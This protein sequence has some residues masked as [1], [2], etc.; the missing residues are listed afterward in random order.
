MKKTFVLVALLFAALTGR[1]CDQCGCGL[2]LGVQP[3]DHANNFGLQWH[4]RYL[5]GDLMNPE[6]SSVE[7]M[8]KHG[9]AAAA[10]SG[11]VA[12]SSTYTEVYSV[13]EARA[14]F[15][16]GQRF[17]LTGSVPLLNNFQ[18]VDNIRHADV[19]AVG[20]PILLARYA[21][22][23]SV[24]GPDTTRLRHRFTL[25]LGVK[26]PLGRHDVSQYGET[27]EPDLQPST[28]TWDELVSVE[29][30]LRAKQWGTSLS[31]VGRYNGTSDEGFQLGHAASFTA[32]VFRV[33]PFKAVK[34]LPS[35]GG[36][37]E[38]ALPD[39]DH[40]AADKTTGGSTIFSD[41][42]VRLWW[43]A[44]G[45][46]FTWEHALVNDLGSLMVPNRERFVAGVTYNIDRD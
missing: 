37:V 18:A 44:L 16:F 43:N 29:Y 5:H 39:V 22:L 20:D 3:Y 12:A 2:L 23:G 33:I 13:L 27:L 1:A 41:L 21:I 6:P 31:L 7:K 25:G 14:Q 10:E 4:M 9:I 15:W 35:V 26:V 19:Y 24:S 28:G 17:S 46:S 42:G 30:T 8:L 34:L 11:P 38:S 32:E 36:Y 40:G 45:F